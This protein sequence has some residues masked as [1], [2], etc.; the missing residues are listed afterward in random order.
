MDRQRR[1]LPPRFRPPPLARLRPDSRAGLRIYSLQ[2]STYSHL[3]NGQIDIHVTDEATDI[4][5]PGHRIVRQLGRGGMANVYLAFQES[6]EREVALK[7]M[8]PPLA[9]TDRAFSERFVREAR[10]IAKLSHPHIS[11]VHDVGVAGRYH[12]FTMEYLTGGDLKSRIRKGVP[13]RAA[14]AIV[15][16]I[17]QALAFAHSKGYVHRDVKPENVLFRDSSTAVLT[18]FGIAKTN[19]NSMTATGTVVGT[20]Y[21]MSPEQAMGRATDKRSD[22]YSLGAMAF[23]MLTGKVPFDG[24]SAVSI[25]IKHVKEPLPELPPALHV[26]QPLFEK[27][28]AK[29]PGHRFQTGEEVVAAIDALATDRGASTVTGAGDLERTIVLTP[30]AAAQRTPVTTARKKKGR[31]GML[32]GATL[33]LA[34]A[35]GAAYFALRKPAQPPT[36]AA[37]APPAPA[38][39][40]PVTEAPPPSPSPEAVARAARIE[41]L[42]RQA[43]DA[44]HARRYFAPTDVAA[45]P[46]F[47]R[48]LE[49]DPG[50]EQATQALAEI[51]GQL[52]G[53]AERAIE[54]KDFTRAE[55]LLDQ[56][57]QADA[58]H[59]LLFSRRLALREYR[60]KQAALAA[61]AARAAPKRQTTPR[62]PPVA[63]PRAAPKVPSQNVAIVEDTRAR[64]AAEREKKLKSLLARFHDLVAPSTLTAAR[65]A[66]AKDLLTQV[67]RLAPEDARVR[68]LPGMLA[69]A[70]LKLATTKTEDKEYAEAGELIKRGLALQPDHRQLQELKESVAEQVARRHQ[71]F[72]SF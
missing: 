26:Y 32:V 51:A 18:D 7:I 28:L 53:V 48:V 30:G 44:A 3:V 66:L 68:A 36:V 35:A 22:L 15:R 61:A 67:T 2:A 59:P 62:S 21:Y 5:I 13:P 29:D 52:I 38:A 23:E 10:I 70:Y 64:E 4:H 12:Y 45:V 72:G 14:L 65:A 19:D 56:A 1:Y 9:A 41:Q 50:N 47:K 60:E 49:L 40:S 55:R 20:P 17:A 8:H 24:D 6:M 46:K 25:G 27:F 69:D 39:A 42:L 37:T 54:A 63:A 11:A 16:Q 33:V 58:S 43:G 31:T 34:L 57:E 71:T